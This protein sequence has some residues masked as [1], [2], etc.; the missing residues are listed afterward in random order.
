MHHQAG[1]D[2]F[3]R[4]PR[5]PI[6]TPIT[7]QVVDDSVHLPDELI[8]VLFPVTMIATL[9]IVLELAC[10][11]AT[12]WVRQLE[13]PQKVGSLQRKA[14]ELVPRDDGNKYAY[15]LE[16]GANGGDLM[17]EVLDGEDIVLAE[18]LLNDRVA[19]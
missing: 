14:L 3:Y 6:A 5:P 8:D 15:L 10:S 1:T 7:P 2:S 16:V 12:S 9:Y 13:G 11:P 4:L 19:A 17:Y 18:R